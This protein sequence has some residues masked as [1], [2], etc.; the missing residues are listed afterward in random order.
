MFKKALKTTLSLTTI[1][2]VGYFVVQREYDL[3]LG[4]YRRS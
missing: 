3:D 1:L 4:I 2:G